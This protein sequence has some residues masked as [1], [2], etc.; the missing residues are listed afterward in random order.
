MVPYFHLNI[1]CSLELSNWHT[2]VGCSSGELKE[3]SSI[4]IIIKLPIVFLTEEEDLYGGEWHLFALLLLVLGEYFIVYCC[5]LFVLLRWSVSLFLMYL[6]ASLCKRYPLA[7]LFLTTSIAIKLWRTSIVFNWSGL[8]SYLCSAFCY[9]GL[10]R[11]VPT[12][13]LDGSR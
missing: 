7:F 12:T 5:S 8:R 1:I 4:S 2:N 3:E 11:L 9:G 13:Y 10:E 6:E